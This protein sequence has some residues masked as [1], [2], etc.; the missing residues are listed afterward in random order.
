MTLDAVQQQLDNQAYQNYSDAPQTI[1]EGGVGPKAGWG[2]AKT[3]DLSDRNWAYSEPSY[4]PAQLLS[5]E[6][7]SG[8]TAYPTISGGGAISFGGG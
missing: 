5:A 1:R 6:L 4:F 8:P 7:V 3:I 2:L